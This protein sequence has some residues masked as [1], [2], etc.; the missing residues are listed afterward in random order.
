[1]NRVPAD[2]ALDGYG[3]ARVVVAVRVAVV[4][5]VAVLVAVGPDWM[6]AHAAT[7]AA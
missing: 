2:T 5:S 7:T 1:M 4:V 3:L 6:S